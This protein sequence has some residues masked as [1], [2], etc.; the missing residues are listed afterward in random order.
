MCQ[1]SLLKKNIKKMLNDLFNSNK[2]HIFALLTKKKKNMKFK[3]IYRKD[4]SRSEVVGVFNTKEKAIEQ[5]LKK[6]E[7]NYCLDS[8]EERQESLEMR[9]FCMCG[10]GPS[11]MLIEEEND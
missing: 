8:R 1:L 4:S 2:N 5:L 3:A 6:G 11:S 7:G 10:C 9:N